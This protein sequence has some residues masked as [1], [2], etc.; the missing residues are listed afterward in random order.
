MPRDPQ[1]YPPFDADCVFFTRGG[2]LVKKRN[3]GKGGVYQGALRSLG[4]ACARVPP[5]GR[6]VSLRSAPKARQRRA[7]HPRKARQRRSQSAPK[8]R[9]HAVG[10]CRPRG[11][12]GYWD[13]DCGR[14]TSKHT[15]LVFN[16]FSRI[17]SK[18][19][20]FALNERKKSSVQPRCIVL[21]SG[22]I[23]APLNV[24]QML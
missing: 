15:S 8:A 11:V 12:G 17:L 23:S 6:S 16:M 24:F 7:K 22:E 21:I 13:D 1:I 9:P 20:T 19:G 10:Q 2:T 14:I 3:S 5:S 18:F 4:Q